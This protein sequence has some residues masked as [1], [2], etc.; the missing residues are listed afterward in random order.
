MRKHDMSCKMN[1]I[2]SM[3]V[4]NGR[5]VRKTNEDKGMRMLNS[6]SMMELLCVFLFSFL[7]RHWASLMRAINCHFVLVV[8]FN[9]PCIEVI[10]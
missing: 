1:V 9:K 7:I 2:S 4:E 6:Q 10:K 5:A 3:K 8:C